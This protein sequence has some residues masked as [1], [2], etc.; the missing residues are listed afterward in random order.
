MLKQKLVVLLP[1]WQKLN[2]CRLVLLY[3]WCVAASV[4]L[5]LWL[6][7]TL[8]SCPKRRHLCKR[9]HLHSDAILWSRHVWRHVLFLVIPAVELQRRARVRTCLCGRTAAKTLELLIAVWWRRHQWC[10]VAGKVGEGASTITSPTAPSSPQ[11]HTSRLIS[12]YPSSK[13]IYSSTAVDTF[14]SKHTSTP[15]L[16]PISLPNVIILPFE[17]TLPVSSL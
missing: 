5:P 7:T 14:P 2:V 3:W 4:K 13:E 6:K 12:L 9:M 15:I 8:G 17:T 10:L 16:P 1:H 11:T